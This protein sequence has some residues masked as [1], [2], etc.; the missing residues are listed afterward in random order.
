MR[1]LKDDLLVVP[2]VIAELVPYDRR[3][4]QEY[5]TSRNQEKLAPL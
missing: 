3:T 5:A 1:A 2:S 4:M